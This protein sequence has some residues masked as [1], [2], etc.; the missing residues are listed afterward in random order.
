MAPVRRSYFVPRLGKRAMESNEDNFLY[1]PCK[2]YDEML[3][4]EEGVSQ[5]EIISLKN[6]LENGSGDSENVDSSLDDVTYSD[7]S[8]HQN[9][10]HSDENDDICALPFDRE[11]R[12]SSFI[13]RLGKKSY[14]FAPRLGKKAYSFAPRLGKKAYSFAPRLGK[15]LYSF[16]PRLGKKAY[17]F[18]P[19]L[20]KRTY[21]FAPR[22]G[23]KAYSFAPRLG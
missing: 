21:S 1:F 13:P 12:T 18:A 7:G 9:E 10:D 16:A 15:R 19:R 3:N 17:S 20:G 23:K 6:I 22:L 2:D 8:R 4:S 5:A 11:T 14:S